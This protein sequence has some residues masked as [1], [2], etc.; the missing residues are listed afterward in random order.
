V[1]RT[2]FDYGPVQDG[3]SVKLQ[4]NYTG[5][6]CGRL[7]RAAVP[8]RTLHGPG[9]AVYHRQF[10][11][12]RVS[13]RNVTVVGADA[14]P[15]LISARKLHRGGPWAAWEWQEQRKQRWSAEAVGAAIREVTD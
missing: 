9:Q 2:V 4:R 1:P 7:K 15:G 8:M 13:G 11:T 12:V 5:H 10:A 6:R 3:N 14:C